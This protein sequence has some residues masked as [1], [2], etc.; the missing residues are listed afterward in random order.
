MVFE[1]LYL[2]IDRELYSPGDDIWMKSYLVNGLSNQL[3]PG[4]KS[5]Y[6]QLISESG[7]VIQNRLFFSQEGCGK[8]DFTIPDTTKAGAYTIRAFTKYQQNFGEESY[9]HKKIF[10]SGI[11]NSGAQQNNR[12]AYTPSK[13]NASF[14]PEG[15]NLVVNTLNRIAFKVIDENGKGINSKGKVVDESGTEIVTFKSR[16]RG[17]GEFKLKAESGKNYT[18]LID[19]YPDYS[20]K[21]E[22]AKENAIGLQYNKEDNNLLFTVSRNSELTEAQELIFQAEHKD[23]VVFKNQILLDQAEVVQ[24]VLENFF[25]IGISKVSV[26]NKQN[27]ILAERL[28]FVRDKN[29]KT[30][31]ISLN[32]AK[33]SSREK[34]ELEI[35][36]QL[37]RR[38]S[39]SGTLSVAV[40][41]PVYFNS[42]GNKQTIESYLLLDSELKGAIEAPASCFYDEEDISAEEK[43]DLVMQINGWRKYYWDE[44]GK[45]LD[46]DLPD[47]EDLGLSLKGNVVSLNGK[48]P[49][50]EG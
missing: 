32:K 17:M 4:Y 16:Y 39:V 28:V 47:W 14:L 9:F 35:S 30:L 5:I 49:V 7:E 42:E 44:L 43:L 22:T 27:T 1:K 37:R 50:A 2:H 45:Y 41:Q 3:I 15:G 36:P 23:I 21:L 18:V 38:D 10:I 40:V 46:R 13:I 25:P 12:T 33:Y 26:R 19:N 34:V 8:S 6:A 29:T 31:T 48:K 11:G 24:P 20:Y